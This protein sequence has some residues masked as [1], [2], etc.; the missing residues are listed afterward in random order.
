MKCFW[1]LGVYPVYCTEGNM[2]DYL[3]DVMGLCRVQGDPG[4]QGMSLYPQAQGCWLGEAETDRHMDKILRDLLDAS[5]SEN[6]SPAAVREHEGQGETGHNTEERENVPLEG[7]PFYSW[8]TVSFHTD[9]SWGK[10]GMGFLVVGDLI[11]S[12]PKT[13]LKQSSSWSRANPTVN[14]LWGRAIFSVSANFLS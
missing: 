12:S 11:C 10:E 2:D 5:Y 7:T 3:P 8:W 6:G 14:S 1:G 13:G 9:P 4:S